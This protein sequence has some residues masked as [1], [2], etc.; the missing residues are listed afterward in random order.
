MIQIPPFEELRSEIAA[1]SLDNDDDRA[2]QFIV[3]RLQS[4]QEVVAAYRASR[5]LLDRTTH[6]RLVRLLFQVLTLA[7]PPKKRE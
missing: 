7:D 3:A 2:C 6:P 1:L 5:E 4:P